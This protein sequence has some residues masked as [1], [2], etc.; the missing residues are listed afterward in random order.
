VGLAA[1]IAVLL[2]YLASAFGNRFQLALWPDWPHDSPTHRWLQPGNEEV[3]R[4]QRELWYEA[5]RALTGLDIAVAA[6]QGTPDE[7]RRVINDAVAAL[8]PRLSQGAEGERLRLHNTDFGFARNL[9]GL[10]VIWRPLTVSSSVGCW[11]GLVWFHCALV[12]ALVSTGLVL[13]ALPV[14]WY[15]LPGYVRVKAHQY[16][17]SFFSALMVLRATTAPVQH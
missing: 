6:N 12:W 4:Q 3:S 9:T 5:I 8:R 13:V 14:G 16:A 10:R 15:V 2:S 1:A 17:E 7:V 11:I